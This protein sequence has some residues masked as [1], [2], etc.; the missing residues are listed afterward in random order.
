[1]S[2]EIA[3]AMLVSGGGT[4][5]ARILDES[6][7]GILAGRF[8]P[9][10]VIASR[11]GIGAIQKAIDRGVDESDIV[12]VPLK[13][14]PDNQ[15]RGEAIIAACQERG[16]DFL[17]QFGWMPMTPSN[18][19]EVYGGRMVNQ[20]PGPLRQGRLGFGGKGMMG[21]AVHTAVLL[22]ARSVGREFP[23]TEAIAQRVAL[24]YDEGAV[25]GRIEV[26]IEKKDDVGSLQKKVLSA[27]HEVQV[28]TI[29]AFAE[30]SVEELDLPNIVHPDEADLL[31]EAK[32]IARILY[33]HG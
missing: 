26:P 12:I 28:A 32:R 6:R 30:G 33:P 4:T 11:P 25:L 7:D 24:Q 10:L 21:M 27:E 9:R 2:S 18:V 14:Y 17:G 5:M 16:V 29:L 13:D 3:G 31:E 15:A 23:F 22:F 20:H 19:I 1:M 8:S